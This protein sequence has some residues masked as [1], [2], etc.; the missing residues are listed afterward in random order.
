[1]PPGRNIIGVAVVPD[2]R[3]PFGQRWRIVAYLSDGTMV[4]R[5]RTYDTFEAATLACL[6]ASLQSPYEFLAD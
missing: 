2:D 3:H 4:T 5:N 1:M 6:A